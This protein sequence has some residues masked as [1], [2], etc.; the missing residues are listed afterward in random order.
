MRMFAML[1]SHR[2]HTLA[3]LRVAGTRT[4]ETTLSCKPTPTF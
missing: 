4:L 3:P 2:L 1:D